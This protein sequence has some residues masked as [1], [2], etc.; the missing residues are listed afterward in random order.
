MRGLLSKGAANYALASSC[1][2][3]GSV[4]QNGTTWLIGIDL[5]TARFD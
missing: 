2:G 1:S 3:N 5:S 4:S